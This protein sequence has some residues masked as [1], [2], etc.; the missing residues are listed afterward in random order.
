MP[1]LIS[2]EVITSKIFVIRGKKVILDRDLAQLYEVTTKRLNEQVKRNI[3]RFPED[4]ML[5]LT[6]LEK[7]ELVALCDRFSPMKHSTVLPYVFTEQG[8]A[9]LS[10]VLNSNRAIMVNIQ[11]MRAFTQLRRMLLTN[12]DLRHKI[13]EMEKK[14]DKQ[15]AIVFQAMKQ[16]L[17][18]PPIKP[19]PPIGFRIYKD[20]EKN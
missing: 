17:E 6:K 12:K 8:V 13:E 16:L 5:K 14:Y 11:I 7:D 3:R 1:E 9:M 19:K 20:N 4:F 2:I 10:G 15:F 18:P